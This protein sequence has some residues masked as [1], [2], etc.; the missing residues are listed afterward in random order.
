M[1]TQRLA[2]Q[3]FL[4]CKLNSACRTA[5]D[6][7]LDADLRAIQQI[8]FAKNLDGAGNTRMVFIIEEVK[9]IIFGFYSKNS[10]L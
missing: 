10:N 3:F 8:N 4:M 5:I 9:E 6:Q 7:A 2:K 1:E